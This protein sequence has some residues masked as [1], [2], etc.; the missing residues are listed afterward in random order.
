VI[1]GDGRRDTSTIWRLSALDLVKRMASMRSKLTAHIS[2]MSRRFCCM[3]RSR[4][5]PA[6]DC[7][8]SSRDIGS[9][10]AF[11]EGDRR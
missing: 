5:N 1:I 11:E 4:G 6:V 10:W 2:S 3:R 8:R 7:Q 9:C